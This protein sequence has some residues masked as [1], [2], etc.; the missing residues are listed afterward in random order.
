MA[1][2][3]LIHGDLVNFQPNFGPAVVLVR[4]GTLQGT[5]DATL[6]GKKVCV[7]GDEKQ[8]SVPGCTYLAGPFSV[9]GVGTL[10]IQALALN[11]KALKTRSGQKPVLLKG[12]NFIA[13]FEVQT[14][15]QMPPPATTA[16]ASPM[17]AGSGSFIT[18]NKKFRAT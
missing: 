16:D 4:P 3:I 18:T 11:Q 13:L 7:D 5:G 6:S 8:V 12:A 2:F 14:P 9:P 15:A 10:K 17:Y 1:D